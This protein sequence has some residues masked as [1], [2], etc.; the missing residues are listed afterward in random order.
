MRDTC[1]ASAG[2]SRYDNYFLLVVDGHALVDY[3]GEGRRK[4]TSSHVHMFTGC[5]VVVR[6]FTFITF[7]L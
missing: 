4:F 2:W 1:F 3:E 7:N 6:N 5:R